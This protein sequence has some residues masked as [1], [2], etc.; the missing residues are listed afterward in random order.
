MVNIK[1]KQEYD[2]ETAS[3]FCGEID[4]SEACKDGG[5]HICDERPNHSGSHRCRCGHTWSENEGFCC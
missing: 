3:R 2:Q 1:D 4:Q 5:E